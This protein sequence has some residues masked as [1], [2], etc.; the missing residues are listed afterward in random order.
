[1]EFEGACEAS[2]RPPTANRVGVRTHGF[3]PLRTLALTLGNGSLG[4]E[5]VRSEWHQ[6]KQFGWCSSFAMGKDSGR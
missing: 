1:M 5:V 6:V 3:V 4:A 2:G